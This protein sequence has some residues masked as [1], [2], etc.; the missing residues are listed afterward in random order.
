MGVGESKDIVYLID[1][2]L[3]KRFVKKGEHIP[4]TS[5][6]SITGTPLYT[7]INSHIGYRI[8]IFNIQNS[9]VEMI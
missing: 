2:G 7:S 5:N 9:H 8:I 4:L 1:F 6:R 3:S